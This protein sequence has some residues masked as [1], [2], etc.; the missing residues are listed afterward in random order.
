MTIYDKSILVK[1][2]EWLKRDFS[3]IAAENR[4]AY[5]RGTKK[6]TINYRTLM[7]GAKQA[8][9]KERPQF[10]APPPLSCL[11]E[12]TIAG[13]GYSAVPAG[14]KRPEPGY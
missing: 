12:K 4:G 8:P 2:P 9:G 13:S 5:L 11:A 6:G 3:D 7:P 10:S 1:T 14:Q